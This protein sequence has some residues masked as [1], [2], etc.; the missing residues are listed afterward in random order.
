[1]RKPGIERKQGP[2]TIPRVRRNRKT[3]AYTLSEFRRDIPL[4]VMLMIP[5]AFFLIFHYWPMFGLS[6]AFQNY[7]LGDPFLSADADWVGFQWF[8]QLFN[9][10]MCWRWIR[11]TLILSAYMLFIS[12]PVSIIMALLLNEIRIKTL[13]K[14]TSTVS[15]LPYFISVTVVVGIMFN[16]FSV[17]DGIINN[18]IAAL[19]GEKI[20]FMGDSK[21]FRSLFIGSGIWQNSGFNAVVFTAAIAGIDPALYEAAELDGCS[22]FKSILHVTLPCIMPTII[23]MFLL[24]IGSFMSV[25]YEKIILMYSPATYETADTLNTYVYR[26]GILDGK[27]SFATAIGLFNSVCNLVLLFVSN[28]L[29]KKF[30]ETSLW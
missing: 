20:D 17:D 16:F 21:Y 15:L 30:S 23:T 25:G 10:P 14:F 7:R 18:I 27:T 28:K 22:R 8:V 2:K 12:F 4:Y 29:T 3:G 5:V 13:K 9:N 6:M 19:G 26:A 24:R 11:N 1:M